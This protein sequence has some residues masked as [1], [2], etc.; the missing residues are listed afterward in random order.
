MKTY[1]NFTSSA[2]NCVKI[3][4]NVIKITYNS[5]IDKEYE[6]NCDKTEEFNDKL[7][8]TLKNNESVGK[9]IHQCVNE[10]LIVPVLPDG[11]IPFKPTLP[12]T[13]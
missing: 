8:N 6:F 5:N 9:L 4:E 1:E 2:V 11:R 7:S 13:K 10:G 12:I 3:G